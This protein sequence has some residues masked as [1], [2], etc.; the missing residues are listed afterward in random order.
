M[1]N[2]RRVSQA[3]FL[4]LF[5]TLFI[6]TD[7]AGQNE[8]P[9]PVKFFLDFDPLALVAAL[10]SAHGVPSALPKALFL[11]LILVAV[12]MVLGR[13]FCGWACPMGTL[14][15]LFSYRRRD[16]E[17]HG[18]F[19]PSP[20][21]YWKYYFLIGLLAAS[22]FSL[23]LAGMF[24]PLSLLI[25]S[26]ALGINPAFN[27]IIN[28]IFAGLY[29]TEIK[30]VTAWSEP[31]YQFLKQTMLSF[32]QTFYYQGLFLSLLF[33]SLI[34]LNRCRLR[35]WCRYLCPLGALLGLLSRW[36]FL[37]LRVREGCT[38]C[39]LCLSRCQGA[40][41]PFPRGQWHQSECLMCWNCQSVCPVKVIDIGFYRDVKTV[42]APDLG[43]RRV[44]AAAAI[45][46]LSVP[47]FR[48]HP[49]TSL[50]HPGLVRPPGAQAEAEFLRRCVKC[51]E[52][53]K[54]CITNGLQ[55]TLLE[56]GLE[57][58]WSPLLVSRI[59]YCE[60]SCTLCGQVCPTGAIKELAV[61]E[62]QKVKIGLAFIDRGRCLPFAF[63]TDCI[64]CEE[65]C[66]TPKKAIWFDTQ[67][68]TLMSGRKKRVKQPVVD[69]E[70]CIGCG[71]CE[72]KCPVK[73]KAAIYV[74]SV[75]ESRSKENQILLAP[76]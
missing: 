26:L 73:D 11:S 55:P 51:G 38:A 46:A 68:V 24:D 7:Y 22:L 49:G 71:I 35:F 61:E 52:C 58:I 42:P 44:L 25:R 13:V 10:F 53:M 41:S 66:P 37:K 59:G 28:K 29:A 1:Q 8:I 40:A 4:L 72:Y 16:S 63:G 34:A 48:V 15:H 56:A 36:S 9:Y 23:Q 62:K 39:E 64:V 6:K 45:G 5:L 69:L 27:L 30:A 2:L 43:R 19:L 67:E 60:Y 33:I 17:S 3:L 47:A 18:W 14:H 74:T 31:L 65:H 75:G 21:Q 76:L 70:L 57:G 20:R 12:T 50:P 32:Q 54:V